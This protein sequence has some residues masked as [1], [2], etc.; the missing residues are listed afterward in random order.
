MRVGLATLVLTAGLCGQDVTV[1]TPLG[2]TFE[3]LLSHSSWA[4]DAT[5]Q[6][7]SP[8]KHSRGVYPVGNGRVFA[9]AGLGKRANTLQGITGP[10]Y[11]TEE[12]FAPRG[13][14][15]EVTL[16]LMAG[17]KAVDLPTQ[18]IRRVRRAGF[19]VTED[20]AANGLSLRTLTFATPGQRHL[21]RIIEV[22]NNGKADVAGLT[23]RALAD[24]SLITKDQRLLQIYDRGDRSCSAVYQLSGSRILEIAKTPRGLETE[25]GKLAAGGTW[26]GVF[27]IGT[28]AGHAW[29]AT[30]AVPQT[31]METATAEVRQTLKWWQAKL[32][33]TTYFDT[34]RAKIEDL[35]EDWKVMMLALRCA[36]SGM[37]AP[38][39]NRHGAYTRQTSG[40]LL[41]FLRFNMWDEAGDCLRYI[42]RSTRLLGR[43]QEQHPLDLDFSALEGKE[44]D[45]SKVK[46]PASEIPSWVILQHFWYWRVTQDMELIEE[47]WPLLEACLKRQRRHQ[48]SLMHFGG[49]EPYLTELEALYPTE[50][51][52]NAGLI[53]HDPASGRSTY[54]FSSGVLFL[55]SLQAIGEMLNGMDRKRNPEGWANGKPENPL[56][57]AHQL[58]SFK[59]MEELE[60]AYW[61]D[62][63]KFFAPAISPVN[64]KQH[65]TVMA[66][67]NLMPLWVGWTFPSGE[68]SM[69]NLKHFLQK[70]WSRGTRIGSTPGVGHA[71]G[72]LQGML[73]TALVERDAKE[74]YDA[75]EVM[76]QMAEP[77]GEW[78]RLYDTNGRPM[79]TRQ[80]AW[81]DRL[82]PGESGINLDAMMF[83]ILGSRCVSV[84]NWDN[85]DIRLKLRLPRDATFVTVKG[86]K[87]DG[88]DLNLFFRET[89]EKLTKEELKTNDEAKP[90]KRRD[91]KKSHRRVRFKVELMSDNPPRGYWDVGCN[92]ATTMFVRY[93]WRGGDPIE[94]VEFWGEETDTVFPA[95]MS[96]PTQGVLPMAKTENA[97]LL[98]LTNRQRC[99]ELLGTEGVT[100]IDV[101]LPITIQELRGLVL[102]PDGRPNHKSIYL[103][104]GWNK[105][106]TATFKPANFWQ[107]KTWTQTMAAFRA[108]GGKVIEPRFP[109]SFEVAGAKGW[110]RVKNISGGRL[111]LPENLRFS[112]DGAA[113]ARVTV[114]S[115]RAREA[116]LRVGSGCSV[117]VRFHE[118]DLFERTGDRVS[119][120]DLDSQLIQLQ[121]GENPIELKL[122]GAGAQEFFIRITD[123]RGLPV[124]GISF[125]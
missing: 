19:V 41:A 55:I 53:A 89:T 93:L 14:F 109:S 81:P 97:D 79:A 49:T 102:T 17:G 33:P 29:P 96:V 118:Q 114:V 63:A 88:R 68:R 22:A 59:I 108:A 11:Q 45:W 2:E 101:G 24:A 7:D 117:A 36:H 5:H 1:P 15:G 34:D 86:M 70:V 65:H 6:G 57:A 100:L 115:D 25:I 62:N 16:A 111:V 116:V 40:A 83:A 8:D 82:Q 121:E 73:L 71:T 104:W 77:A 48:G 98:C 32:E 44:T 9:Y 12:E 74:R 112:G 46:I 103:D 120:P 95:G 87:K 52:G 99:A 51:S 50:I 47:H 23:L 75:M 85:E 58:R 10:H 67:A 110:E 107:T 119:L 123:P 4:Q 61:M 37:V 56:G 66:N 72:E 42:F 78:G 54:S 80:A 69:E 27:T 122:S 43:L 94:E 105:T 124:S 64:G 60:A 35:F 39:V 18:R 21:T 31:D 90:D 13:N 26:Q 3:E 30:Q 113:R 106:G 125:R 76:L 84:P 20:A 91:P 28:A 38:M 92:A